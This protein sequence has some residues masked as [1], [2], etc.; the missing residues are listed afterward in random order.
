MI[1]L[2]MF[3]GMVVRSEASRSR[4]GSGKWKGRVGERTMGGITQQK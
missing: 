1:L 4:K 3:G 2:G